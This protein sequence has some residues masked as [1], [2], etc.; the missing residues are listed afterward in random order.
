MHVDM[1][2]PAFIEE[3]GTGYGVVSLKCLTIF[4]GNVCFILK[5]ISGFVVFIIRKLHDQSIVEGISCSGEL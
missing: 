1:A 5:K 3:R 2:Y 4:Y